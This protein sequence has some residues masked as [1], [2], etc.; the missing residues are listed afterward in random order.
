MEKKVKKKIKGKSK[1]KKD[2]LCLFF[3]IVIGLVFIF[4][5]VRDISTIGYKLNNPYFLGEFFNNIENA[6]SEGILFQVQASIA[7][8]G[9]AI[10]ALLSESYKQYFFGISIS[11]YIMNDKYLTNKYMGIFRYK[12]II[13]T[14]LV[15]VGAN[16]FFVAGGFKRLP[17]LI[18]L[19]SIGL[20]I[21][22]CCSIFSIFSGTRQLKDE[23]KK[24]YFDF[25]K[26]TNDKENNER[27][28]SILNNLDRDIKE[29]FE[30]NYLVNFYEDFEFLSSLFQ[31]IIYKNNENIID[32]W[33]KIYS[34]NCSIVFKKKD[35][36]VV[37]KILD[38]INDLYKK[39][40]EYNNNNTKFI[41][42]RVWDNVE[43][44]FFK[45][46][47]E[48]MRSEMVNILMDLHSKLYKNINSNFDENDLL[49]HDLK[50][51]P[52]Y[53]Y[54]FIYLNK[55]VNFYDE[56]IYQ[57]LKKDLFDDIIFYITNLDSDNVRNIAYYE[58]LNHTK[59]LI[60][61]FDKDTLNKTLFNNIY[62]SYN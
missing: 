42:L 37:G 23:M 61:S 44:D 26:N 2:I 54:E 49:D 1:Y 41:Y 29:N 16:Y 8:L 46:I 13:V 9:L 32:K 17:I 53:I 45:N 59:I 39:C 15:L 14:E 25:F 7:T 6:D 58:L 55:H 10:I 19:I 50:R 52:Y 33:Q 27:C 20:V 57:N 22:M 43:I 62:E 48:I 35:S 31:P 28:K 60:D 30:G 4:L 5:F 56:H 18:F 12:T 21:F 47:P 24:F 40:N 38:S 51:F 11:N 3:I 34:S 36:E